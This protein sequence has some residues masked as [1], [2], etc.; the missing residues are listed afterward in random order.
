MGG[1]FWAGQE[2]PC[3]WAKMWIGRGVLCVGSFRR[4][5]GRFRGFSGVLRG[6]WRDGTG[7]PENTAA[8]RPDA[9][10]WI[11]PRDYCAHGGGQSDERHDPRGDQGRC[12]AWPRGSG[13]QAVHRG[14]WRQASAWVRCVTGFVLRRSPGRIGA[15]RCIAGFADSYP[16]TAT[17]CAAN[18]PQR[19]HTGRRHVVFGGAAWADD[20]HRNSL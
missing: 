14:D 3:M 13:G 15:R 5:R 7:L 2:C 8:G 1:P 18:L 11:S 17:A 10:D 20:S 16:L 12:G 4:S 9:D 6:G 19:R